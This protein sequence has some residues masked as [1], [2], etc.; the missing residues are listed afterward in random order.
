MKTV[1]LVLMA[2]LGCIQSASWAA[3]FAIDVQ[4]GRATGMAAAVTAFIDDAEAAYYNPAGL[5]QGRV[6]DVRLG[7]TPIL[8]SFSFPSDITGQDT[9]AINRVTTPP[10]A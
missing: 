4:G 6:L 8:P 9:S 3:G 5:A 1:I 10:H 2:M 7:A